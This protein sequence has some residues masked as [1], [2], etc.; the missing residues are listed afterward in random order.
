MV[1]DLWGCGQILVNGQNNVITNTFFDSQTVTVEAYSWEWATNS[2]FQYW[3]TPDGSRNTNPIVQIPLTDPTK[4]V[5]ITGVFAW[6][7]PTPSPSEPVP[8]SYTV[9]VD[10]QPS[11]TSG[12]VSLNP[13]LAYFTSGSRVQANA[14][15]NKDY[16]FDH[17]EI[18]GGYSMPNGQTFNPNY[19]VLNFDITGDVTIV[20]YFRSSSTSP[21]P[22]TTYQPTV[23]PS[24][25][26]TSSS[27]P[28]Q[29][30][31][32]ILADATTCSSVDIKDNTN[33]KTKTIVSFPDHFEFLAGDSITITAHSKSGYTFRYWYHDKTNEIG[34]PYTQTFIQSK[35]Y[36]AIITPSG[37][38]TPSPSSTPPVSEMNIVAIVLISVIV[39]IT[40]LL[41]I[42][43]KKRSRIGI[44]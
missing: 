30:S 35:Q 3:E 14:V 6:E 12:Y 21:S 38:V 25:S 8:D 34:N 27:K 33:G 36:I 32:T 2:K 39:T 18:S 28:I 29:L 22:T 17:F 26:P 42:I 43:L 16:V 19:S 15:P 41:M 11:L 13:N 44:T 23:T 40:L 37:V 20:A 9:S 4:I 10:C 24:P 5:Q 7:N 31:L 1:V